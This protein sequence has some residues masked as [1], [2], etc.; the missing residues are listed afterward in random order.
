MRTG[1]RWWDPPQQYGPGKT[2]Y[3]RHRLWSADGTRQRRLQQARAAAEAAGDID[4]PSRW[5]PP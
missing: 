1:A 3:E 5:T 2:V 4:W